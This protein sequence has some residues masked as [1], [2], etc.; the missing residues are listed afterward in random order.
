[1]RT[2]NKR[3][4]ELAQQFELSGGTDVT[5]FGLLG[6]GWEMANGPGVQIQI[7]FNALPFTKGA[8]SYA[9]Q[10]TFP[11]GS[12]DNRKFY[13]PHVT[14]DGHFEKW[15]QLLLFDAQTSGGLLLAVPAAKAASFTAA[16]SQAGQPAWQ[17]GRIVEGEGIVVSR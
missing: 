16:A 14:F 11:G 12:L 2:L 9:E 15:E 5:G 4:S 10:G 1:M 17:I 6:H 13:G 7:D 8:R 3:A